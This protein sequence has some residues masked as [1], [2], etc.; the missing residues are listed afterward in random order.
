MRPRVFSAALCAGMFLFALSSCDFHFFGGDLRDIGG[1]YR[2]KRAGN[3]VRFALLT[4]HESGGLIIDE[5]GWRDPIIIAR[6][7]GSEYWE[8][9]DTA[10]AQHLRISER[11]RK[12]DP[13]YHSITAQPAAQAWESLNRG[14]RLW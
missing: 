12:T 14:K 7:S 3:P 1:G 6:G 8:A 11:E 9:I 5:V 10:H 13:A 2:L 4:P